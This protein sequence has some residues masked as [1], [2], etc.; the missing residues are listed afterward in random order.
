MITLMSQI[1]S[2]SVLILGALLLACGSGSLLVVRLTNPRLRGLGWLGGSFL[3]GGIGAFLIASPIREIPFVSAFVSDLLILLSLV[4]LQIGILEM[5]QERSRMPRTGMVLLAIDAVSSIGLHYAHLGGWYRVAALCLLIAVQ[6]MLTMGMLL[7]GAKPGMRAPA[8]FM[9]ILLGL[10]IAINIFRSAVMFWMGRSLAPDAGAALDSFAYVG[11][12]ATAMGLA[13]GF[14]WMT[15][16]ELTTE[17]E[18]MANTDP[19]TRIYNRR[20][21][22]RWCERE[23]ASSH[24]SGAPFSMLMIDLDHF[25]Q[26]NDRFGH[27][28]GDVVLCAAVERMQDAVRG[29]D[30]LGRWGGE[31]FMVMLPGATA[32]SALIVAERVR[33]NIE[34]LRVPRSVGSTDRGESAESEAGQDKAGQGEAKPYGSRQEGEYVCVT[35]SLGVTSYTGRQDDLEAMFHRTDVALYR[36][37]ESGRNR[38]IALWNVGDDAAGGVSAEDALPLDRRRSFYSV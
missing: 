35:V 34:R 16:A 20:I 37:K 33:S 17:L 22:R 23:M 28:F 27:Q 5:R 25:K 21:F 10:L 38:V 9:A 29:I 13:F 26:V 30:V 19:L 32:E 12:I 15:S 7:R 4:L 24:L 31:E 14:F 3:V 36:A 11:F 2:A 18:H 8:W 1:D 6:L